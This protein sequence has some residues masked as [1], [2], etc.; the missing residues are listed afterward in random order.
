MGVGRRLTKVLIPGPGMQPRDRGLRSSVNSLPS[1]PRDHDFQKGCKTPGAALLEWGTQP[2]FLGRS[3][4]KH[5]GICIQVD[6]E[7]L[8]HTSDVSFRHG[9][10]SRG[11]QADRHSEKGVPVLWCWRT[12]NL[13]NK[14]ATSPQGL[15]LS[16]RT[17]RQEKQH[18]GAGH[19]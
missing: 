16:G 10:P 3:L 8:G 14:K 5:N 4:I 6:M 15:F 9:I 2:A 1:C 17:G 12:S 13:K 19:T 18:W 11:S 7:E